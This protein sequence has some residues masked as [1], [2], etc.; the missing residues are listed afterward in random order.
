VTVTSVVPV[1][2]QACARLNTDKPGTCEAFPDRIPVEI[3]SYGADHRQAY[4]DDRGLRF[5]QLDT[6]AGREAF[7]E[8]NRTFGSS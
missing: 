6:K 8:W 5:E 2:C 3:I 1:Q 4:P 7:A